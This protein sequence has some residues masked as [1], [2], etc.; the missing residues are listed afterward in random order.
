MVRGD[1][2]SPLVSFP[3]Q[4]GGGAWRLLPDANDPSGDDVNLASARIDELRAASGGRHQQV[5][6]VCIR[7]AVYLLKS[8]ARLI[9]TFPLTASTVAAKAGPQNRS[10]VLSTTKKVH[11]IRS[12]ITTHKLQPER[13]V[14]K[15][16]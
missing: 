3:H 9:S 12:P 6:G 13:N 14:S 10:T 7:A 11:F 5:A 15:P 8:L 2:S 1:S 16:N 4:V